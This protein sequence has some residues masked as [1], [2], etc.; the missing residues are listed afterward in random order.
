MEIRPASEQD[1]TAIVAL[2]TQAYT[3]DP[4]GGRTTPYTLADFQSTAAAGDLLVV[5]AG[6]DL[7]GV[8]ALFQAGVRDGQVALPGEAELSR[9][10]VATPYRRRGIARSL[11]EGCVKRASAR[12]ASA[13]ALWSRPHQTEAHRLYISLSFTR[14][15]DRDKEDANDP[16]L[17]FVRR[18]QR[19]P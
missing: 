3:D 16:R 15:P 17:V 10:A 12:E 13:L 19:Q 11:A 9:L 14:A 7:A 8:V 4:R 18:L 5:R 2:W 1:V 6:A